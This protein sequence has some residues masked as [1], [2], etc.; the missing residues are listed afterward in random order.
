MVAEGRVAERSRPTRLSMGLRYT[1]HAL[2]QLVEREISRSEVEAVVLAP[3]GVEVGDT[4]VEYD[5]LASGLASG[6][7]LHVVVVR[8]SEPLLVITA[9]EPEE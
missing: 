8:G 5:G 1:T 7:P 2:E 3:L 6:R 9:Y 4:A